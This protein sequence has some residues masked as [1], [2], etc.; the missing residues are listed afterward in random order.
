[1]HSSSTNCGMKA[2]RDA[3]RL[4]QGSALSVVEG[5]AALAPEESGLPVLRVQL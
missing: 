5:R 4:S 2:R 1:M 3:N